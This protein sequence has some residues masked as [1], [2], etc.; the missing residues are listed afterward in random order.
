MNVAYWLDRVG[1]VEP[2]LPAVAQGD[3]VVAT[4]GEVAA[5]AAGLATGMTRNLGLGVGDHVAVV[6]SNHPSYVEALF[7][8][9]WAGLVAVPI[10]AKLH[11]DEIRWIIE[12]AQARLL[13]LSPQVA[14]T[15][16][17]SCPEGLRSAVFGSHDYESLVRNA[18]A[19]LAPRDPTDIAWLFYTSGTTGRPKGAMLSHR[20][21]VSMSFGYLTDIDPTWSGDALLHAAPMSHGSGLLVIP[22]VCRGGLNVIPE[23]EGFDA[24]EVLALLGRW[25]RSSM[26][27]APT[28]IR[29]LVD[30]R[31]PRMPAIRTIVWGGAAMLTGDAVRAIDRFGPCFAQLYGQGE[32]PMTATVLSRAVIRDRAHPRW[33]ERLGSAGVPNSAVEVRVADA[34]DVTV[35]V[36]EVGEVLVRG[37]T[38][39][40]G[41][42]QDSSASD[43][44]LRGGWLHTGDVGYFDDCGYLFL[45]DR[46]KDMIISGGAN[47]YPREV[48]EILIGHPRVAEASVIGRADPEWGEVVVAYIVGD[49]DPAELDRLCIDRIARFK[50]PKEYVFVPD[51]PKNSTGKILKTELRAR[52]A[53][54][55]ETKR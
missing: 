36:G 8:V 15:L 46:S 31:A 12:H 47:I 25:P 49:P 50:R 10:N 23:S 7:G 22:H 32:T 27:A 2:S 20:N 40:A 6:A 17:A 42:W 55:A 26:F 43:T 52:D 53:K 11:P 41:Y 13:L 5:R 1:V 19:Q 4:Y 33:L 28:M 35:P 30:A 9:W 34:D 51:L 24:D 37:D 44:A 38:V 3:V 45:K 48:E 21:L 39:M 14:D 16:G 18:P 29:R 54:G